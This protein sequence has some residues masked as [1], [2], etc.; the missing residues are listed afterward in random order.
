[1]KKIVNV[2]IHSINITENCIK[3]KGVVFNMN[4]VFVFFA[5]M[6]AHIVDDY[7]LQGWLAS[8]KQKIW[9][10]ENAP[11]LLYKHDYIVALIMHSISW[12]FSIMFPLAMY[13]N[14]NCGLMYSVLFILNSAVHA[15][16]DHL[17]ANMFKINLCIDQSIHMV[18][19]CITFAVGILF[20]L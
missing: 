5:M 11:Q 14:F 3:V 13:F 17:K 7:Y 16:V 20:G 15:A 2:V 6:F 1:M 18:Q 8:A 10:E 9:W 4:I 12:T 19:I